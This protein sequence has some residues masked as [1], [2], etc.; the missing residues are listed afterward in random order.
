MYKSKYFLTAVLLF[1]TYILAAQ[2]QQPEYTITGIVYDEFNEPMPSATVYVKNTTQGTLSDMEGKFSIK[3]R[4]GSTLSISFVGYET[5][6]LFIDKAYTDLVV[7]LKSGSQ[8]EELVVTGLGSQRKISTVGAVSTIETKD[9]QVPATSMSNILG[10][11]VAGIINMQTSGEPGKN[12][13][14]FWVRGIGTFGANQSALVLIDGLEGDLNSIDP[15]DVESFSVLKDASATAVYGVRGANGVV[16]VTTKRGKEGHLRITARAN[17]TI[18]RLTKMPDYVGAYDYARLVNEAQSV[19]GTAP[20]YSQRDLDV[21]QYGL[22][23]DLFPDVNWQKEIM[24]DFGFQ[25]NYYVSGQGGGEIARYFVSLN[26]S[27]ENAA[28]KMDEDSPYRSGVGYN[29]YSYRANLDIKLTSTTNM[30]FGTDGYLTLRKQ[31]GVANTDYIWN[32][33]SQLTPVLIP[34]E[35]STGHIPAYGPNDAYSP[36]VMLNHTGISSNQSYTGKVTLALVQDLDI[37]LKGLKL[38]MQA[39]YD[40]KSYFDERRSVLPEMYWASGRNVNGELLLA[41]RVNAETASYTYSQRQYRKYHFETTLTYEKRIKDIHR[42]SGLVYY[43]M[44]DSKDT[45]DIAD[46][47]YGINMSMAAIPK[48]YQGLSSRL[49]YGYNDTYMVDI[50]FGYTGSENFQPGRQ[51]GFFPSAALGWIPTQYQWVNETIPWLSFLKFR[52]SYGM[53]GSDRITDRRFPYLTIVN[54]NASTAWASGISGGITESSVG[55]DNLM[56]EKSLKADVGVDA[57]L[58]RDKLTFN[59]DFFEDKR[60]GIFQ[61]RQSIPGYVGL[62]AMP[63][64]NVGKM[65]SYGSDGNVAFSHD[66]NRDLGFTIRANFTYSRNEIENWEQAPQKYPYQSYNGYANGV[67]RGYIALGL[68]KDEQDVASNPEQTFG[69]KVLPGDI[70]YKDING[71]GVINTDDRVALSDPT[72]PR[73]M[74]GFGGEVRYKSLTLGVLFKGRGH[75]PYYH[76]GQSVN[77]VN[78][79]M[80]YVPFH[81]GDVGNVLTVAADPANRWIPMDYVLAN[82]IDPALAENPNARFPRL[83]YGYNVNNSQLSTWWQGDAWYLR[84]QEITLNYHIN[85]DFIKKI[86]L[87]SMDVQFVGSNLWVWDNVKLFDPEQAHHNGRSYPIPARYSL[88]LYLNF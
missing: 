34:L 23:P 80:G 10:G 66:F 13:S 27:N 6:E 86:G 63:Y 39:A 24:R 7:S 68:F 76:V 40:N 57:H 37:L 14:E 74:Y 8:L 28:Y 77:G 51:F 85:N 58:F 9:L 43:Y 75:T 71:D 22:D 53:V 46:S 31:P 81:G 84:L 18:S 60:L 11:R 55:A 41:K 61:Q 70:K 1:V 48:R 47:G 73:L 17:A 64:G 12:I 38:R 65:R 67:H 69:G 21:I 3:V 19:R 16:L 45:K 79:G 5:Y 62:L 88:Q 49:T 87:T 44:S 78:N 30:Y 29:T 82:G 32:A 72:Y 25:Q 59:I 2:T 42:F 36:Y 54:E 15:A 83:D 4:R 33:Q 50:N 35:Y 56:W 20:M 26:M 52:G